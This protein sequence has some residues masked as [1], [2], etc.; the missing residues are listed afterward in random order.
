MELEELLKWHQEQIKINLANC[1]PDQAI[2]HLQAT[3]TIASA[4]CKELTRDIEQALEGRSYE[5]S[6]GN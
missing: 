6:S 3:L 1:E 5:I 2:F 4:M